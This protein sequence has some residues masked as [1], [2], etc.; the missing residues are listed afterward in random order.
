MKKSLLIALTMLFAVM[1]SVTG[2]AD[3]PEALA[4][5]DF[6]YFINDDGTVSIVGCDYLTSILIPDTVTEIEDYAFSGC[7][8]LKSVDIPDS[9]TNVGAGCFMSCSSLSS[10][11]LGSGIK[12]I[13][14][15]VFNAC[16]SLN[17]IIIPEN[18][19]AASM[20]LVVKF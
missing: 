6:R 11:K 20:T 17:D 13:R 4:E 15:N 2:M 1:F 14:T 5:G 7:T 16:T 3:E 9:V 10:A 19:A 8:S 18:I 12:E